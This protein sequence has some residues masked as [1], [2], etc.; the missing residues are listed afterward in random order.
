MNK[1]DEKVER[2]AQ[3][4]QQAKEELA[5]RPTSERVLEWALILVMALV[6]YSCMD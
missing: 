5:N 3:S 6:L 2:F 1:F 4:Y